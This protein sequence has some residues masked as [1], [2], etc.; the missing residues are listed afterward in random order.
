M[1]QILNDDG[2]PYPVTVDVVIVGGGAGGLVTALAAVER[3][4][5]VLVVERDAVPQGSTSLSAGLI[6][7]PGTRFAHGGSSTRREMSNDARIPTGRL[8]KKIQRHV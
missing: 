3:G 8:M 6:P 4:L 2:T 1:A 7:A 5:G